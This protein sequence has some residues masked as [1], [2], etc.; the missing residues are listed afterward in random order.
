M[1][2]GLT[3]T[4][5]DLVAQYGYLAIFVFTF[6]ESSM[7]FPLLPSEVVLPVAA[8][9]LVS[10]PSSF[11][12][13][14]AATT[15]GVTVGSVVAYRFFGEKGHEALE[16]HGGRVNVSERRLE[17]ASRWFEKW[18][19]SSVLWGRLL[20]VLR[21]VISLPAGFA[22]MAMWKF[23]VYSTVGG[24]VFNAAV[25]AVVYYGRQ[26]SVYHVASEILGTQFDR[27]LDVASANPVAAILVAVVVSV[28]A[29]GGWRVVRSRVD[30]TR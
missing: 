22:G 26:Q 6:L 7:L 9:L 19:E 2:S 16:A 8:G 15:A 24:L 28:A 12:L 10:G 17:F 13:F 4:A 30:G 27:L 25:A 14:V 5:L 29:V 23:L 18:G 21:S 20:P 1:P 3:Q 11:A